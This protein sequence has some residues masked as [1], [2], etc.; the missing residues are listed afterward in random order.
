MKL[1]RVETHDGKGPWESGLSELNRKIVWAELAANPRLYP[2]A[3]APEAVALMLDY[4][5][6]RH[7]MTEHHAF[8]CET[9]ADLRRWF[10][11]GKACLAL[12]EAGAVLTIYRADEL[13]TIESAWEVAFDRRHAKRIKVRPLGSLHG[14]SPQ[15]GLSL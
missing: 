2:E 15:R 5:E 10:P 3:R 13:H 12:A 4:R 1:F 6:W 14:T 9:K 7:Y 8:G 11:S